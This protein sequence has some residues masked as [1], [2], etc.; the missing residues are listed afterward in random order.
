MGGDNNLTSCL[1]LLEDQGFK[2]EHQL[3]LKLISGINEYYRRTGTSGADQITFNLSAS[4]ETA[5]EEGELELESETISSG[6]DLLNIFS[7]QEYEEIGKEKGIKLEEPPSQVSQSETMSQQALAAGPKETKAME[8]SHAAKTH[9][10]T[11]NCKY[12]SFRLTGKEKRRKFKSHLR[13]HNK[14]E[15]HVC[16][17]CHK[18]NDNK[19]ELEGHMDT[20]HK[21]S[22]GRLICG[23][24]GCTA[25]PK[26][27]KN[28][29]KDLLGGLVAHVKLV[30]DRVPY[31][32]RQCNKPFHDSKRHKLLHRVDPN[33]LFTCKECGYKCIAENYMKRHKS[34]VHS[35]ANPEKILLCNSCNFK[36]DG[37]SEDEDYKLMVHKRIHQG[38]QISCDLCPYK[39][40][41]LYTLKKHLAKE[42]GLGKIFHCNLCDYK[43]SVKALIEKHMGKHSKEKMFLCDKCEFS[44]RTKRSL[45][46]HMQ[47]HDRTTPKY[48]CDECDYKSFDNSNFAAHRRVKH[49]SLML[50]CAD[51]DY[52]T[53]SRRSLRDHNKKHNT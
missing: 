29:S 18:K 40:L 12:C 11:F 14:S 49:G 27:L 19:E 46:K 45:N 8:V 28:E 52:N 20:K 44:G 32:C 31:I 10:S 4:A 7:K 24:R 3:F 21:D 38:G 5:I 9:I 35:N 23:I 41:K 16:E 25:S 17:I 22:N 48:V 33:T 50:S 51:C 43:T 36:T 30:H 39:S 34:S 26:P 13:K 15:H 37:L 53:K 1:E 2:A 47:R 42:H 6:Q